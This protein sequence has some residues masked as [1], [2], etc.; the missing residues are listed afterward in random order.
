MTRTLLVA[1]L[2]LV[3]GGVWFGLSLPAHSPRCVVITITNSSNDRGVI[4]Y[5]PPVTTTECF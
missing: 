3:I 1:A 2:L 5:D 4:T